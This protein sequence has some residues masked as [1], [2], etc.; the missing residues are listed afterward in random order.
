MEHSRVRGDDELARKVLLPA[1]QL[2]SAEKPQQRALALAAPAYERN[3]VT[4]I[5]LQLVK[6]DRRLPTHL[7]HADG[8]QAHAEVRQ[9]D[10]DQIQ[11]TRPR[12]RRGAFQVVDVIEARLALPAAQPHALPAVGRQVHEPEDPFQRRGAVDCLQARGIDSSP[13]RAHLDEHIQASDKYAWRHT[14][15]NDIQAPEQDVERHHNVCQPFHQI[16]VVLEDDTHVPQS[17]TKCRDIF[18]MG[19]DTSVAPVEIRIKPEVLHH[20]LDMLNQVLVP[21]QA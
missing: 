21:H 3:Q 6:G 8:S 12:G 9:V 18:L 20:A 2:R 7:L 17:Q 4:L 11:R 16:P 13:M 10:G 1:G 15:V 14:A 19:V 5:D